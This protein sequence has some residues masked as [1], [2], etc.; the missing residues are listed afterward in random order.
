MSGAERASS[1]SMSLHSRPIYASIGSFVHNLI[2]MSSPPDA[3]VLPSR[4]NATLL[5]APVWADS[6]GAELVLARYVPQAD[7]LVRAGGRE[8]PTVRAERHAVDVVCVAGERRAQLSAAWD[9]PQP[10]PV[11]RARRRKHLAVGR[12]RDLVDAVLVAGERPADLAARGD[13]PQPDRAIAAGGGERLSIGAEGHSVHTV[14]R[15]GLADWRPPDL[16]VAC[17]VPQPYAVVGLEAPRRLCRL[18]RP[19]ARAAPCAASEVSPR[20]SCP[21]ARGGAISSPWLS[22]LD[23]AVDDRFGHPAA[24]ARTI[25]LATEDRSGGRVACSRL[26]RYHS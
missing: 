7:R 8:R 2:V 1:G 26:H 25:E 21:L 19:L 20:R 16:A 13:V 6:Q 5:T 14:Q 15:D 12:E 11:V 10:D 9:V 3:K 18:R 22:L 24:A 4:L 23:I 17:D